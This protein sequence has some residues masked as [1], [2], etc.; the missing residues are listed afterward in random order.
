MYGRCMPKSAKISERFAEKAE[1]MLK[2][3]TM[4]NM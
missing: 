1:E 2:Q 4:R 3:N